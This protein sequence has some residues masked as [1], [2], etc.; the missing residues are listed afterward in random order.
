M[1]LKN[2]NFKFKNLNFINQLKF[3]LIIVFMLS[4]LTLLFFPKDIFDTGKS[5]CVSVM[6]FDVKCY[7]CG[8]T[9]G[10]QHLI[11]FD[12]KKAYDY[13]P[14]SFIVF[15]LVIYLVLNDFLNLI[16]LGKIESK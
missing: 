4:G 5:V 12:F 14:L 10:I 1:N 2:N 3:I 15:P 7:A 9:R 6:L 11:H 13:N 16:K 8:L